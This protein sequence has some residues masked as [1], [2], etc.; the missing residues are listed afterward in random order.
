M[1]RTIW[2]GAVVLA[3]LAGAACAGERD[4]IVGRWH[5]T[6]QKSIIEIEQND[7]EFNGRIVGLKQPLTPEGKPK[8]DHNNPDPARR[9]DSI[10]GLKLVWGFK[11]KKGRTWGGGRIY[12]PDNGKTY[13]CKLKL[14]GD[15]LTVR[16]SLDRW[17]MAGRT[18]RWTRVKDVE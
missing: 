8:N 9:A 14:K 18:V 2:S 12:D 11:H 13:Y 3:A 17:G 1:K 10:V 6:D 7:G 4:A 16:G 15:K 5:T